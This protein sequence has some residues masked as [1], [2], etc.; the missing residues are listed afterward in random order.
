MVPLDDGQFRK[1]IDILSATF[2]RRVADNLCGSLEIN[3]VIL[4]GASFSGRNFEFHVADPAGHDRVIDVGTQ[5]QPQ[6]E[7]ASGNWPSWNDAHGGVVSVV[8][9][10]MVV[11]VVSP[12]AGLFDTMRATNGATHRPP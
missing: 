9:C 11:T 8:C 3:Q 12:L 10:V 4:S 5:C 7:S 1:N 2:Q 6:D